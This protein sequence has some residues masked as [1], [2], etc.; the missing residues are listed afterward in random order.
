MVDLSAGSIADATIRARQ[1]IV[2]GL[3][4]LVV[5]GGDGMTHLGA[6]AVAGTT[7]PLGIVAGGTG[8]DIAH[9]L[10]LPRHDVAAS[11]SAIE[12]GLTHGARKVD[13]V[14]V[15][16]PGQGAIEWYLGALSCGIDAAI[17]SR[18]NELVWPR[19]S[20]RYVRALVSV[21]GRFSP[22]G[23]RVTMDDGVWESAGTVVAVANSPLIGG[24]VRIA[25]DAL[26]DDGLLDVVVAGPF[27]RPEVVRIFPGMYAGRHVR[28]PGVEVFRTRRVLIEPTDRGAHPPDAFAD[29]ERV[30]ALPLS[31]EV[32]PGAVHV[33][34]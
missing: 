1:G 23:F 25:P 20:A 29:G 17:N 8:N 18:A 33:L 11:V 24:G 3:D 31:A 10:A 13:A 7:L 4:A 32:H 28:R 21:L 19:G 9:S 2:D 30:G 34:A 12:H 14:Q 27:T 6:N 15:G 22:Y 16:V 5:V 26:M